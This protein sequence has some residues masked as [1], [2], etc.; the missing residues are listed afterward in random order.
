MKAHILIVDDEQTQRELAKV[1][2]SQYGYRV[3]AF[4]DSMVALVHF[5]QDPDAYDLIITDMT[6]PGLTGDVLTQKIHLTRPDIPV[7][8]C[9]GYSEVID[10]DKAKALNID[11][12]LYKPVVIADLLKAIRKVLK[13]KEPG[14]FQRKRPEARCWRSPT[15]ATSPTA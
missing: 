4:S 11:S 1:A 6:M 8:L 9:T 5:Q 3:T 12:F 10:E 15:T 2:L 7:I 14:R 13:K